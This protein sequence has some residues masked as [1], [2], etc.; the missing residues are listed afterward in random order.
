M[1]V[2]PERVDVTNTATYEANTLVFFLNTERSIHAVTPRS[3]TP[4]PRKHINFT[5]DLFTLPDEGLFNLK[6]GMHSATKKWLENKPYVWRL[7][8]YING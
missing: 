8:N 5:A 2:N 1:E 3:A 6:Y 7:A 4:I